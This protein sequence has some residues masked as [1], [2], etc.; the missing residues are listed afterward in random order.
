MN[1][2]PGSFPSAPPPAPPPPAPRP[3][4]RYLS[5]PVVIPRLTYVLLAI[6]LSAFAADAFTG[7]LL[8]GLGAKVNELI[9]AGEWWRLITPMFLHLGLAHIFFNS[10]ALYALG[11][12]VER[13]FGYT[14]FFF[15]YMLAG[16]AGSILSFALSPNPS[17]GASGAIFGLI[18]ALL[19]YLYRH[20]PLFGEMGR[21]RLM[22]ILVVAGINLVIGLSPGI[23]NW[24]H[25]G[26]LIG[27][28]ALTALIGPR[29]IVEADSFGQP[30][31]R[32][33]NPFGPAGWLAV[34]GLGL[35][36]A[37]LTMMIANLRR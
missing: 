7:G 25:L 33:G 1:D 14:R 24:G 19:V 36:L 21:Q 37:V 34:L 35:A 16:V 11:L 13:V 22:N 10:Y 5:L 31:V 17:V 28:A 12:Q 15:I 20:R 9:A 23:D 18:G 32:D 27:G 30:H 8:A 3:V 26:G 2:L 6:N 29:F 4:A